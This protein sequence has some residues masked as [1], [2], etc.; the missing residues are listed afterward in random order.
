MPEFSADKPCRILSLDGGGAKGFYTLG[1]LREIEGLIGCRMYERFD[2][3]FGTSTGAIIAA[4]LVLGCTS[5]RDSHAVQRARSHGHATEKARREIG[6][7]PRARRE[8]L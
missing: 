6:R 2:L 8:N 4:L 7:P 5:G 1:V 3:I